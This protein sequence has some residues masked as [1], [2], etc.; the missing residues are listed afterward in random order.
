MKKI[1]VLFVCLFSL[2]TVVR[3]DNDRP[4]TVAQLPAAAQQFIK[5]YFADVNVAFAKEEKDFFKTSYEVL[6]ANGN[7]AEF[8]SSGEW[9]ELDCKYTVVPAELVPAQI[10][11]YV[12]QYYA[13]ANVLKIERGYADYE[14]KLSNRLELTFNKQFQLIDIDD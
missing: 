9:S 13:G 6:F 5:K 11:D 10:A 2:Q 12:K 14:V 4:I 1:L 3:A 8:N 7:K